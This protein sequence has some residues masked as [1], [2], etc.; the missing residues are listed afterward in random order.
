M[1]NN[2]LTTTYENLSDEDKLHEDTRQF[3]E[4]HGWEPESLDELVYRN[5][6]IEPFMTTE[7]REE[8][9]YLMDQFNQL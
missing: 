8:A 4:D 5:D 1:I 6:M 9:Q 2:E 7:Q 3:I